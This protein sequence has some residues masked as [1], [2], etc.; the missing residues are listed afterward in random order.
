MIDILMAV[1]QG[2][3]YVAEQIESILK[4][5]YTDWTLLIG[6]DGSK[7]R[8]MEILLAYEAKYPSKIRVIPNTKIPAAPRRTSSVFFL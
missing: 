3:A 1:Y 6:D 7:D 5:T 2:E 4:Q 8:T